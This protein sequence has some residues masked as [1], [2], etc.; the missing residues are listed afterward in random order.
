M[1]NYKT[2][3]KYL[4]YKLGI[5]KTI[6]APIINK[7]K[8]VE[9]N[10][11]L[12]NI[13][14]DS[15]FCFCEK[16]QNEHTI[17]LRKT[18]VEKLKEAA[19]K[20]PDGIKFKIY[21]AY[22]SLDLQKQIWHVRLEKNRQKFPLMNEQELETLTRCQIANPQKGFGGHQTGGAVDL[23][24]CQANGSELDMGAKINEHTNLTPTHNKFLTVEQQKNRQLL[25]Q[26]LEQQGFKNYPAEW[27][28]FSYGDRLW[29]AYAQQKQCFYG[30][31]EAFEEKPQK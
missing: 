5:R 26:I 28:H 2:K 30:L 8:I 13:A 22:R 31:K 19:K 12:I 7:I 29:A 23:T 25:K 9:N 11:D 17:L 15:E 16:L 20:L 27:W 6:P 3:L 10:E 18:V 1:F 4:L 14:H 24:L 21:S